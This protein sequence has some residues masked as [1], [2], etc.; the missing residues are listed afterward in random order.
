MEVVSYLLTR[1]DDL[2]RVLI[3]QW[4][5]QLLRSQFP[6]RYTFMDMKCFFRPHSFDTVWRNG[7][8][9]LRYLLCEKCHR[10]FV[11]EHI[12]G[13]TIFHHEPAREVIVPSPEEIKAS[14]KKNVEKVV[15]QE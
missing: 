14:R 5:I 8:G 13:N 1:S 15:P 3:E 6:V 4:G 11:Q 9:D 2:E 7:R 10:L 12:A